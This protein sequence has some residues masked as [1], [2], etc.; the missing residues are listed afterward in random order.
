MRALISVYDKT[1]LDEFARGL[2]DLDWELVASGGTA[3][4]LEG[5]GLEVTRVESVTAAAGRF[6]LA[7]R[8]LGLVGRNGE[9]DAAK[10]GQRSALLRR[11]K[12]PPSSSRP[13]SRAWRRAG[14]ILPA[15][16]TR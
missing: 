2:A 8:N 5:L 6:G 4:H 1:G 13:V 14:T 15:S 10:P 3:D 16:P 7:P 9:R 11:L 12:K